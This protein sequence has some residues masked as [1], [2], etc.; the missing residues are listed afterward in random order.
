MVSCHGD[1]AIIPSNTVRETSY[2]HPPKSKE[3]PLSQ[4]PQTEAYETEQEQIV[5]LNSSRIEVKVT[6]DL[7]A[8]IRPIDKLN[9]AYRET[10]QRTVHDDATSTKTKG[11]RQTEFVIVLVVKPKAIDRQE[12][13]KARILGWGYGWTW[14]G[15]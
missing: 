5:E 1:C 10:W 15:Y 9:S 12:A 6:A 4:V 7:F 8:W 13:V 14:P 2:L 11:A 3:L